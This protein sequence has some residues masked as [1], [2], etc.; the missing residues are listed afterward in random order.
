MWQAR[1]EPGG[2]A[3]PHEALSLHGWV[4]WQDP[5]GGRLFGR[6]SA[7]RAA[8]PLPSPSPLHESRP[9]RTHPYIL[10]EPESHLGHVCGPVLLLDSRARAASGAA[11]GV[12][13][14]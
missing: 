12:G 14:R 10:I 8:T 3:K 11:A 9:T 6:R 2:F 13:L 5:A 4:L 1:G 7:W